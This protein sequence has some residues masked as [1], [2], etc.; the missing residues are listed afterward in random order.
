MFDQI[1]TIDDTNVE[2]LMR[3]A[4]VYLDQSNTACEAD[5][6][7]AA[8]LAPESPSVLYHRGQYLLLSNQPSAAADDFKKSI[9]CGHTSF[10][11][12]MALSHALTALSHQ[13]ASEAQQ[14]K[15]AG[16]KRAKETEAKETLEEALSTLDDAAAKF[17][18]VATVYVYKGQVLEQAGRAPDAEKAFKMAHKLDK[19]NPMPLFHLGVMALRPTQPGNTAML[20]RAVVL[21]EQ[22]V[23]VEPQCGPAL[24]HLGHISLSTKDYVKAEYWFNQVLKQAKP[25][26][27]MPDQLEMMHIFKESASMQSQLK[28]EGYAIV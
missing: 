4:M 23:K 6:K 2:A 5:Y 28:S 14:I 20:R 1:L 26:A 18:G 16:S 11:P 8:S 12:Y 22:A 17:S 24:E 7:R 10:M 19:T 25:H 3:R 9:R 27:I 15:N 21:L 13:K